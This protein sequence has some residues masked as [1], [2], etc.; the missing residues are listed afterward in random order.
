MNQQFVRIAVIVVALTTI[1]STASAKVRDDYELTVATAVQAVKGWELYQKGE[2]AGDYRDGHYTD[3]NPED[4]AKDFWSDGVIAKC[5]RD[6]NG[7]HETIFL[8][9]DKQLIYAACI[10]SKGLLVH[11][12]RPFRRYYGKKWKLFESDAMEAGEK[13]RKAKEA[14]AESATENKNT[15]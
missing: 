8:V 1:A 12:A 5:D 4:R 9:K 11:V 3:T 10:G 2:F 15:N 6:G 14:A 13:E 7:H